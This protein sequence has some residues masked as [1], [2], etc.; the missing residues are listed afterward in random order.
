MQ[1]IQQLV[2]DLRY[3]L[4]Q[5]R[6][7]PGFAITAV[8]TL[9]L[10]VGATTAIFTLIYQVM[11]RPLPV[12]QPEQ[13]YKLG[14]RYDCC[15]NGGG[16]FSDWTLFSWDQ[17]QMFRDHLH[18]FVSLTAFEAGQ[19]PV[20][21]RVQGSGQAAEPARLQFV[22]G[23]YF[24]TLGV[25]A[26]EGRAL[27][28]SDDQRGVPP[29]VV[30]SY[31][32]W[33]R[34]FGGSA[35]TVGATLVI[36]S[37]PMTV[38][39]IM[40]PSFF[41]TRL[42]ADP[43]EIWAPLAFEPML[44]NIDAMDHPGE[45]WLDIVG[46][47]EPG[48]VPGTTNAQASGLLQDWLKAHQET[49]SAGQITA[50]SKQRTE[51]VA[52]ASGISALRDN[53]ASGLQLLFMIAGFVLLI[54]CANLANLMLV[55]SMARRQQTA[56]RLAL[57]APRG[58]LVRQTLIESLLVSV[59]GSAVAVLLA[60]FGS[61]AMLAMALAGSQTSPFSP[62]PSL[63][64]LGFALGV[65]VLAG[66]LFGCVPAWITSHFDP[67]EALRGASRTAGDKTAWPQKMLVVLQAA[68]SLAL[69]STAGL[70][71]LSLRALEHQNLHLATSGRMVI[72]INTVAAGDDIP[73]LTALG[74][75]LDTQLRQ[76]PGVLDLGYATFSPLSGDGWHDLTYLPG[77]PPPPPEFTGNYY[78]TTFDRIS[79]GYFG[80]VGTH[81]LLGRGLT[82]ADTPATRRVAVVNQAFVDH[83]LKGKPPLGAHFGLDSQDPSEFEIVGVADNTKYEDP[84]QPQ[85]PMAFLPLAQ[86]AEIFAERE[87]AGEERVHYFKDI[88]VHYQGGEA[89]MAAVLRK[90]IGDIDPNLPI[91]RIDSLETQVNSNFSQPEMLATLTTAFGLIALLLAAIGIYG[92][93]AYTVERR[94]PE[95][96]LRMALGAD[97][98]D[99][100]R[101]VLKGALSQVLT[102]LVLGVPLAL[103]LG[104]LMAAHLYNVSSYNPF[105][106][107]GA[108]CT[109]ILAAVL[110]A[111]V[112]AA[113]AA[114]IEPVQALR[115]E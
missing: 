5:L 44:T 72:G 83:F 112:P 82:D 2:Q 53:Y 104:R 106:L 91:T 78:R 63:P 97:R 38:A 77:Q 49:L 75:K 71:T 60:V 58:R 8:L 67:I 17:Y 21:M 103:G 101:E 15:Y 27:Q 70:L 48:F 55:R 29:Q 98:G 61:R 50:I 113:R 47:A 11:L 109:L 89:E 64:V 36:N 33:Q 32:F 81:I 56:V 80:A 73:K 76:T 40:P 100:L 20:G 13:L 24:S 22:S 105:I 46:R 115:N 45:Y 62:D 16:L 26:I 19:Q 37:R 14:A 74:R 93:T 111:M 95:V 1:F 10:G 7:S 28:P 3:A 34:R 57:G 66:A 110:A 35:Q 42:D 88:V 108:C 31:R 85:L 68:L 102:G 92:V 4:R 52:A 84:D 9:A 12:M 30:L 90:A 18:G 107:C 6:R 59:A 39:G 69:L 41:G 99:V 54:V 79:P 65:A 43:P 25:R 96:G 86:P 114:S 23:N 94:T 51:W 87:R